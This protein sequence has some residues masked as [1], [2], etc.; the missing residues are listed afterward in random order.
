MGSSDV[1]S[2]DADGLHFSERFEKDGPGYSI[3]YSIQ[4]AYLWLLACCGI[5]IFLTWYLDAALPNE[6]DA[7]RASSL[8]FRRANTY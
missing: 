3:G 6:Y 1:T 5:Y 4:D 8:F 7:S 2:L